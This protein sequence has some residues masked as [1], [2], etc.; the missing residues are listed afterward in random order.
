M[1]SIFN[2]FDKIFSPFYNFLYS[3]T[4]NFI[5]SIIIYTIIMCIIMDL[6]SDKLKKIIFKRNLQ[7]I[8]NWEKQLRELEET[9]V[10][11]V[12]NRESKEVLRGLIN[13]MND[14][15]AKIFFGRIAVNSLFL[16]LLAPYALW[17]HIKFTY[18]EKVGF[19]VFTLIFFT[20]AG[21]VITLFLIGNIAIFL[22]RRKL[23]K[24]YQKEFFFNSE[25]K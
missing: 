10:I 6:V 5:L 15:S 3:V 9:Y 8:E 24:E 12:L 1:N 19:H 11:A 14:I 20:I 13:M 2:F 21:Y 16:A 18:I 4:G 23:V 25:K 7:M 22:R 17:A